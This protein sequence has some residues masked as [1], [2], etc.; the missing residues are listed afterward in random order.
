VGGRATRRR[1]RG[2]Q[3]G[4]RQ[5]DGRGDGCYP[6]SGPKKKESDGWIAAIVHWAGET[7]HWGFDEI[8][9]G[10]PL[11]AIALLRRQ[12]WLKGD[13]IFPLTVIE[14]IDNGNE[15]TDS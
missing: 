8:L 6:G 7:Y 15:K 14:E 10:V 5:A 3:S 9:W 1:H 2:N 4:L 13:K 12:V 11:S